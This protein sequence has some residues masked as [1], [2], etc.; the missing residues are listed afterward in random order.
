MKEPLN[1]PKDEAVLI[2][3]ILSPLKHLI[4]IVERKS[5]PCNRPWNVEALTLSRQTAQK[6]R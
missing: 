6:R 1:E 3:G 4:L 5:Y 2:H